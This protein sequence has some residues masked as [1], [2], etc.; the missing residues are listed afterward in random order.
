MATNNVK[1]LIPWTCSIQSGLQIKHHAWFEYLESS[2]AI[3]TLQGIMSIPIHAFVTYVQINHFYE[4]RC[5]YPL[6][7]L[8]KT[9]CHINDY[10]VVCGC[11]C[12]LN[13]QLMSI[14][15]KMKMNLYH[16]FLVASQIDEN[17]VV[18]MTYKVVHRPMDIM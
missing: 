15:M 14:L 9:T 12:N 8:V 2:K 10:K 5:D 4:Y 17:V 18:F 3:S 11:I 1:K 7:H 16:P 6:W 13:L